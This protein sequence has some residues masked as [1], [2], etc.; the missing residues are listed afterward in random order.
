MN[1]LI[2]SQIIR[3][4]IPEQMNSMSEVERDKTII[5][6]INKCTTILPMYVPIYS[7]LYDD[8]HSHKNFLII[9]KI[10]R[11]MLQ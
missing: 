7:Y 3:R 1:G 5:F 4:I 8:Q 11:Y 6:N 2:M 10:S 9:Y